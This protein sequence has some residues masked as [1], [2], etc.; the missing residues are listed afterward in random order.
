MSAFIHQHWTS[1]LKYGAN[2]QG[3]T[4]KLEM[5]L[6]GCEGKLAS[7]L[8]KI[9][10]LK[11]LLCDAAFFVQEFSLN[12]RRDRQSVVRIESQ[13]SDWCAAFHG[14]AGRGPMGSARG[15]QGAG[16]NS[17]DLFEGLTSWRRMAGLAPAGLAA[18]RWLQQVSP[19]VSHCSW[20]M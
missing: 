17:A 3:V 13:S 1:G 9:L 19:Q 16:G 20:W 15:G 12:S 4:L 18:Q 14:Q 2:W 7:P 11:L 10:F 6:A 8:H 5:P